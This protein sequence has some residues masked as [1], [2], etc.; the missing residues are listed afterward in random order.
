MFTK[1]DLYPEVIISSLH[2]PIRLGKMHT[3]E[4]LTEARSRPEVGSSADWMR[5]RS[6][7]NS[8]LTASPYRCCQSAISPIYSFFT[9]VKQCQSKDRIFLFS[10]IYFCCFGKV[11]GGIDEVDSEIRQK[12][13]H[14]FLCPRIMRTI[15]YQSHLEQNFAHYT[16][17]ITVLMFCLP[18]I[19]QN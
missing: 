4:L 14:D 9:S 13:L 1:F 2:H 6:N 3:T 17:E 11:A 5:S 8:S 7:G 16:R 19:T 12:M 18:K 15:E 10:H